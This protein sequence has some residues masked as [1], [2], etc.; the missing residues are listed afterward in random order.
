MVEV[1][2]LLEDNSKLSELRMKVSTQERYQ[3]WAGRN[4][5]SLGQGSFCRRSMSPELRNGDSRFWKG[6]V[7][8]PVFIVIRYVAAT[9]VAETA[10]GIHHPLE[11]PSIV[12]LLFVLARTQPLLSLVNHKPPLFLLCNQPE[13]LSFFIGDKRQRRQVY[14]PGRRHLGLSSNSSVD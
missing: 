14:Q 1:T 8:T 6:E 2:G 5:L 10:N 11:L 7:G 3:M 13:P 12:F 4:G 9:R